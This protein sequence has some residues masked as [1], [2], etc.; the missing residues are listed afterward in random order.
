MLEKINLIL[1]GYGTIAL[2]MAAGLY[3]SVKIGFA[4]L[5]LPKILKN[6]LF[7]KKESEQGEI[8]RFQ[9]LSTALAA[10]M[11]TGNIVGVA[12]AIAVGGP[13]AVF[14]MWV[15]AFFGMGTAYAENFLGVTY[16]NK[17]K[18][19]ISG[20]MAY[21]EKGLGSRKFAC[22]FAAAAVL[23]SFGVGN[24]VQSNA[25]AASFSTNDK[26]IQIVIGVITATAA[27]IFILG[28][29]KRIAA[30]LEKIIPVISLFYIIGAVVVIILN[31]KNIP[32]AFASIISGAFGMTSVAGGIS[33]A[34]IKRA[35]TVGLARGIFSNEAGMGSSVFA[36]TETDCKDGRPGGYTAGAIMGMWA[37]L[38]VFID[39]IIC[40]TLTA[41]VILSA[42]ITGSSGVTTAVITAFESGL[43][44]FAG[45]FIRISTVIFAFATI[46]GWCFYGEKSIGY[47]T[48][49]RIAKRSY[50]YLYI[51]AIALG[52]V[53][54]V[55]FVWQLSD[56]FNALMLILNLFGLMYLHKEVQK[57][58]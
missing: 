38:E 58:D 11:G 32:N 42:D 51:A 4:Q 45:I 3:F 30:V 20:S 16:K 56:I 12:A 41:F 53:L 5:H 15:S 33:G 36:H 57:P 7:A 13:G 17:S 8:S 28:G 34:M 37:M 44:Q 55:N 54:S 22:V 39:T 19:K 48:K 2:I 43:G 52:A 23:A 1:W 27:G 10:S 35:V 25:I 18:S 50:S 24:M 31:I 47:L 40:C 46:L 21:L 6:T 29:T 14:W 49:N 9:A 26:L